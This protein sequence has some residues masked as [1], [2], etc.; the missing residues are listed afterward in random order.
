MS[1][2]DDHNRDPETIIQGVDIVTETLEQNPGLPSRGTTF[3]NIQTA[4]NHFRVVLARL[5]KIA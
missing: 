3:P 5:G 1:G 4:R 2:K